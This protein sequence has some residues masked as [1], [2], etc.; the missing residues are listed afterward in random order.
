MMWLLIV[1]SLSTGGLRSYEVADRATCARA[2]AM[3]QRAGGPA[4]AWC[5]PAYKL[6]AVSEAA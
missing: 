6:I 1:A 2:V 3:I 5:I 4:K